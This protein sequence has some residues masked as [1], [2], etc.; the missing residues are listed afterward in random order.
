MKSDKQLF[1]GDIAVNSDNLTAML[2][3][4]TQGNKQ[5][6]IF[7]RADKT[8]DYETLM[9]VMDNLR[10]AGYLKVGLVGAEQTGAAAAK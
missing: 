5:S 7:F 6:T 8:V 9:N 3:Q 10:K 2:D 1:L 4:R